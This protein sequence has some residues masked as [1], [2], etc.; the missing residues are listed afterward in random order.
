MPALFIY[1]STWCGQI[2]LAP[3]S[4]WWVSGVVLIGRLTDYRVRQQMLVGVNHTVLNYTTCLEYNSHSIQTQYPH[5]NMAS[6]PTHWR[7]WPQTLYGVW[8]CSHTCTCAQTNNRRNNRGVAPSSHN[9]YDTHTCQT[10]IGFSDSSST[11]P[12]VTFFLFV[13]LFLANT[14]MAVNQSDT[15]PWE[16]R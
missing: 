3:V 4:S 16:K 12:T 10:C 13:F 15:Q 1:F 7:H 2:R 6:T 5:I 14:Q 8:L 11:M 9:D